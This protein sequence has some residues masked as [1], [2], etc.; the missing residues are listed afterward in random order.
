MDAVQGMPTKFW[1]TPNVST[2]EMRAKLNNKDFNFKLN[3]TEICGRGHFGMAITVFVDEPEDYKKWCAEQKPFLAMN[4][5]YLE[6][7]PENLKAKASKYIPAEPIAT[8]STATAA[9]L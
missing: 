2:D 6:K 9:A 3:C 4:P 1:F 7:V 5:A 8:D